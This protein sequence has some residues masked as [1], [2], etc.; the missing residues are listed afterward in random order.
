MII[1][2]F[3]S[4]ETCKND[5][6]YVEAM[7]EG[8][9]EVD[10]HS[11]EVYIKW[12]LFDETLGLEPLKWSVYLHAVEYAQKYDYSTFASVFDVKQLDFLLT[13]TPPFVKIAARPKLYWLI[14]KI[15]W[16]MPI[17]LS[18]PDKLGWNHYHGTE[19]ITETLCCIAQYPARVEDYF[20]EYGDH[21]ADAVS[22]HTTDFTLYHRYKPRVWER[23]FCLPD[24][25]GPDAG[26]FVVRP[27]DLREIL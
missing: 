19:N 1:L 2:D 16:P 26:A 27:A 24:S 12:Q 5:K 11:Q 14:K 17:I 20:N 10:S 8:L 23:H 25:T 9:A 13:T 21:L 18:V 7:I 3:G 22:D 6:T 4:G 15:P